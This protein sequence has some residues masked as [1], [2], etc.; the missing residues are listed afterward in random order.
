MT[1]ESPADRR[2]GGELNT[3]TWHQVIYNVR[4]F[5]VTS[6]TQTHALHPSSAFNNWAWRVTACPQLSLL[7]VR[8]LN[9]RLRKTIVVSP[10]FLFFA[11]LAFKHAHTIMLENYKTVTPSTST[12][13]LKN[14]SLYFGFFLKGPSLLKMMSLSLSYSSNSPENK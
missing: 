8:S 4:K 2:I 7:H 1:S 13:F 5:F 6:F 9:S 11:S 10:F 3:S 14:N 12:N